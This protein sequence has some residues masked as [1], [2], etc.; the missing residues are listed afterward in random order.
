MPIPFGYRSWATMMPIPPRVAHIAELSTVAV[1]SPS[2]L[3]A[4]TKPRLAPTAST[5]LTTTSRWAPNRSASTPM[6]GMNTS[7]PTD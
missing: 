4:A 2:S 7:I 5:T 3:S 6:I 1:I